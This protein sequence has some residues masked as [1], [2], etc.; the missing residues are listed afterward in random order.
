MPIVASINGSTSP[1][2]TISYSDR[3]VNGTLFL[4]NPRTSNNGLRPI[5]ISSVELFL[6]GRNATRN[7]VRIRLGDNYS[8]TFSIPQA[9]SANASTGFRSV[10]YASTNPPSAILVGFD[11]GGGYQSVWFGTDV[12]GGI[13]IVNS[14]AGYRWRGRTFSG[15]YQ[16]VQVPAQILITKVNSFPTGK[17]DI[18]WNTPTDLGGGTLS[19]FTAQISSSSNFSTILQTISAAASV[20]KATFSDLTPGQ[21]YYVRIAVKNELFS[22]F[23]EQPMSPWSPTKTVEVV[24]PAPIWIDDK[25]GKKMVPGT[26][27]TDSV[28]ASSIVA[29]TYSISSGSLPGGLTLNSSTGVISG[30][31]TGTIG[32]TSTFRIRASNP[33]GSISKA[34]TKTLV[35]A[36]DVW[37]DTALDNPAVGVDYNDSVYATDGESST[38]YSLFSGSLPPG[39]S[40]STQ[41]I[42]GEIRA[43]LS[44]TPTT[45][46]EYIFT[47]RA[48][49]LSNTF[50][51][52]FSI[53]VRPSGKRF[54][55][56]TPEQ[57][58]R[59]KRAS[60]DLEWVD[61]LQG[62]RW[63]GTQWVPLTNTS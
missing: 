40:L 5:V 43:V 18:F 42:D 9:P 59:V 45:Q 60:D 52:E 39:I 3:V 34:F 23:A 33:G 27:Y 56:S 6:R 53:T 41:T 19:G 28:S 58:I 10:Q 57:L 14:P 44:G 4:P 1:T 17:V 37:E 62:S 7:N 31:P 35:S 50:D 25:L 2:R 55:S 15:R 21:K 36:E 46:G 32:S 20:R 47:I 38:S 63:D 49:I 16:Y 26:F 29:P 11:S 13:D 8:S 12:Y 61:I 24:C 30:T 48:T 51:R 54:T 22:S